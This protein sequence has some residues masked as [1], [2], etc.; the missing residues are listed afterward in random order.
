[1]KKTYVK[2]MQSSTPFLRTADDHLI[3]CC[4]SSSLDG[5]EARCTTLPQATPELNF[6]F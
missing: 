5:D 1:M 4:P 3:I 2:V 6:E